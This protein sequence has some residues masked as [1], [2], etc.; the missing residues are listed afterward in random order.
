M[1]V[2]V[3][4]A[5]VLLVVEVVLIA[6]LVADWVGQLAGAPGAGSLR[7][8]AT[9][10]LVALTEP[11]LGPMRRVIPPVRL[12]GVALDVSF[13]L[14]LLGVIVARSVLLAAAGG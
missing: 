9:T 4:L 1:I 13:T 12:G 6:R 8:K 14:V 2:A 11:V 7:S 10:G 3:V 5:N